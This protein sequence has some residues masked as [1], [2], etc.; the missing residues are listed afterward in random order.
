MK[1]LIGAGLALIIG[2]VGHILA[3]ASQTLSGANATAFVQLTP[4]TGS[5]VFFDPAR[6][7]AV[8]ALPTFELT[9]EKPQASLEFFFPLPA[10]LAARRA[11]DTQPVTQVLGIFANLMPVK[12]SVDDV[13]KLAGSD[14]FIQVTLLSGAKAWMKVGAIGWVMHQYPGESNSTAGSYVGLG[15]QPGHP[16]AL[17]EDVDTVLRLIAAA[18][19]KTSE[20]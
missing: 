16:T 5:P 15:L 10:E 20:P 14:Q 18:S 2:S 3:S 9:I 4:V 6:I 19:A 17:K 12:E 1:K 11:T 7:T 8:V 13:M